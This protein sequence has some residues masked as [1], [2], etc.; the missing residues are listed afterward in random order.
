MTSTML[1]LLPL[2]A[3]LVLAGCVNL[4]PEYERPAAPIEAAWPDGE[5]YKT[6]ELKREALPHWRDFIVDERLQKLIETSLEKNL[7]LRIAALNVER[8]R[9]L[10]GVQRAELFPTVA[11]AAQNAAQRTPGTL[12]GTGSHVTSHQYSANLA[13]ASYEI[14]F[15]GRVR[16]LTEEALQSYLATEDARRSAQSTLIAEIAMAWLTYGADQAQLTLQRET[17]A[18]QEESFRLIEESY[19]AGASSRLEFE[20]A[21]ST[22]AA[23]RASIASYVRAV[24]QDKNAL[25]L[26]AGGKVD[27]ALLPNGLVLDATLKATLPEGLPSEVLIN[28]PDILQAERSLIAANADIGVARAAFFPSI[29]LSLSGGSGS[30][31]LSDLF[32]NDSSMWAFTPNVSLPIFTGGANLANLEASRVA[33]RI[34]AATYEQAIQTAFREVAD[35]LATEGT[36]ENEVKAREEYAEAAVNAFELESSRYQH[37]TVAYTDVLT[38]QRTKVSAEQTLISTKLSR[39]SSLV[40]LYKVLGGGATDDE[41]A[42]EAAAQERL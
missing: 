41:K 33:E 25:D 21:R 3:A 34:A 15:F 12:S 29:S 14:D 42:P 40:T 31:H 38:A 11:A 36:I 27:E 39:A 17:L 2:T 28:R 13:M 32:G 8:A 37:G 20:Q 4:A 24:A 6:S 18:S 1:R 26:L 22:V 30:L 7:D 9:A 16:N 19:K 35:A 5:S 10:Y 23:A